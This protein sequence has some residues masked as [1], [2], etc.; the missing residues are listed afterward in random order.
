MVVHP[1][2][3][4]GASML[5]LQSAAKYLIVAWVKDWRM[6]TLL[7][8]LDGRTDEITEARLNA[9]VDVIPFMPLDF[10]YYLASGGRGILTRRYIAESFKRLS[11][12]LWSASDNAARLKLAAQIERLKAPHG[13][14]LSSRF[15]R[16]DLNMMARTRSN[17]RQSTTSYRASRESFKTHQ[18]SAWSVCK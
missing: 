17:L 15:D 13:I 1:G 3:F 8:V 11:D 9:V 7:D 5:T 18:R 2:F 16:G 6:R 12:L 10:H 4:I 14:V